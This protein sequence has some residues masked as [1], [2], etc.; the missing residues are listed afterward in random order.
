MKLFL[1]LYLVFIPI[2]EKIQRSQEQ[3][4]AL[5][6]WSSGSGLRQPGGENL[7]LYNRGSMGQ[8]LPLSLIA[9]L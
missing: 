3:V 8:N 6:Y 9:L 1:N 7:S 5:A 2:E 4:S